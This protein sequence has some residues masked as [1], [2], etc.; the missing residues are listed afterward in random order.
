M[1]VLAENDPV[2]RF[3]SPFLST[4]R[5]YPSSILE[6][7]ASIVTA[8]CKHSYHSKCILDWVAKR[9]DCPNCRA[10]MWNAAEFDR[11]MEEELTSRSGRFVNV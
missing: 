4:P 6:P 1:Y 8:A 10:S 3:G 2:Q 9:D 5:V 11:I 7:S